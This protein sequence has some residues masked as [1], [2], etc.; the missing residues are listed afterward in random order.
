MDGFIF[1]INV[2]VEICDFYIGGCFC[3]FNGR[4]NSV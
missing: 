3:K 1:N 2:Q 4:M